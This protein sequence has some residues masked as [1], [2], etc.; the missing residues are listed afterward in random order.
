MLALAD[1]LKPQGITVVLIHPGSVRKS[2]QEPKT[3]AFGPRIDIDVTVKSMRKTIDA[4][5]IKDT[6]RFLLYDGTTL[7]W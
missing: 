3:S 2:D 7:P 1:D 6:G 5:T 4:V